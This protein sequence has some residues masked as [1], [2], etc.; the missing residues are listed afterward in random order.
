MHH[1]HRVVRNKWRKAVTLANNPLIVVERLER[2]VKHSHAGEVEAGIVRATDV[3]GTSGS[4]KETD[5]VTNDEE[6]T[7]SDTTT[8]RL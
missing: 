6:H 8:I 3:V 7:T 4:A 2:Q 5:A 1:R